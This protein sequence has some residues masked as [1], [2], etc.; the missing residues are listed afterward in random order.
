M[1][2]EFNDI[3]EAIGKTPLIIGQENRKHQAHHI[4]KA[5]RRRFRRTGLINHWVT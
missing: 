1:G 4:V 5:L 3:I 2:R